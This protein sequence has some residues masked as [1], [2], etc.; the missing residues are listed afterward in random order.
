MSDIAETAPAEIKSE[1]G[2]MA[3][4]FEAVADPSTLD[5]SKM[6]ERVEAFT[7]AGRKVSTYYSTNCM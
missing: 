2:V 3:E 5:T 6:T 7:T 4:Y 1:V